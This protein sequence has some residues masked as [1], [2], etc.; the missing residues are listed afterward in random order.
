[1]PGQAPFYNATSNTTS[2]IVYVL[3]TTLVKFDDAQ[4]NCKLNGGHLASYASWSEQKEVRLALVIP[5]C[6]LLGRRRHNKS[7]TITTTTTT[8]TNMTMMCAA[9][10][11]VPIAMCNQLL[12]SMCCPCRPL[13]C[14]PSLLQIRLAAIM[15]CSGTWVQGACGMP[16]PAAACHSVLHSQLA[17][18]L[19]DCSGLAVCRWRHITLL[20]GSCFLTTL[21]T[22]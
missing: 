8:A 21:R 7:T 18:L 19:S 2:G 4:T 11:L 1:M 13:K 16:Q 10:L 6:C 22:R 15:S 20:A 5:Q 17:C 14:L 12:Q 9:R 3:N